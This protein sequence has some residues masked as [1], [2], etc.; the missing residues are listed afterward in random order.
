M[1]NIMV[2]RFS[3]APELFNAEHFGGHILKFNLQHGMFKP[4]RHAIIVV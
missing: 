1:F 2:E 4:L 3:V